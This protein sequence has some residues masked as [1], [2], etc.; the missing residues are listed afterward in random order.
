MH[1]EKDCYKS[2]LLSNLAEAFLVRL[3]TRKRKP[4]KPATLAIFSSYIRNHINPRIGALEVESIQNKQLKEFAEALVAK[5]LAP[6]TC[7]EMVALVQKIIKS[8]EDESGNTLFVRN[9][10]REFILENVADVREQRQPVCTKELLR[11]AMKV[12]QA[13]TDKYR[14]IVAL[15]AASGS[16]IGELLA[17]RC[18]DDGGHSG[19]DH[20]NSLLTIRTS[21]WRSQEQKPK[22]PSSIRVVDLAT[23]VNEMLQAYA[24]ASCKNPGDYLFATRNGTAFTAHGLHK[25]ALVPLCIPGFH[26]L[27][28]WRVSHLKMVGTPEP[29]LKA[30]IG[31]SNGNDITSRYDRSTEDKEWR[32]TWANKCGIGFDLPE[33]VGSA[34]TTSSRRTK[35]KITHTLLEPS[36]EKVSSYQA[37]DDDLPAMLFEPPTESAGQA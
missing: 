29:L 20:K 5:D 13:N 18:G 9:W 2:M 8:A 24:E 27:R 33:M 7:H 3:K 12:R 14:V 16:R 31:H 19:W 21:L 17:L 6:K 22:T 4:I 28:R 25:Q 35:S 1:V 15:L 32:Q 10:N 26:S 36:T 23:P 11:E 34:R 30:W 37:S